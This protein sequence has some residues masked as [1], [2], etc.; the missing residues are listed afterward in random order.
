MDNETGQPPAPPS[1]GMGKTFFVILVVVVTLGIVLWRLYGG[2]WI[3][4]SLPYQNASSPSPVQ[5]QQTKMTCPVNGFCDQLKEIIQ[6]G[7][8]L[9]YGSD[10]IASEAAILASFDGTLTSGK[11]I[12]ASK[13]EFIVLSILSPK[14]QKQA[15]YWFKGTHVDQGEV[16][17]GEIIGTISGEP[18]KSVQNQKLVFSMIDSSSGQMVK[19]SPADFE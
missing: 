2:G 12:T 16:K 9:G 15:F 11:M 4:F 8:S 19:L 6:D 5:I 10:K 17:K 14:E 18:I 7:A 13:E 3:G 1:D